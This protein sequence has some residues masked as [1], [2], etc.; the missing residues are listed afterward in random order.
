MG[1]VGDADLLARRGVDQRLV[2]NGQGQVIRQYQLQGLA[3][4]RGRP[5]GHLLAGFGVDHMKRGN[6]QGQGVA[7]LIHQRN[8]VR[9]LH[10]ILAQLVQCDPEGIPAAVGV[11]IVSAGFGQR[12]PLDRDAVGIDADIL[13][14]HRMERHVV[15][16][17]PGFTAQQYIRVCHPADDLELHRVGVPFPAGDQIADIP[18][19]LP[20]IGVIIRG[21]LAKVDGAGGQHMLCPA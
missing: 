18:Q 16:K 14:A 20:A 1:T 6:I 7:E 12:L 10:Q 9:T 8:G 13:S 4:H 19:D 15:V 11:R 17:C 3:L 21:L 5:A 2:G